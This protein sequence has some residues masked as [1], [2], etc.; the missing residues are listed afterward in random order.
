MYQSASLTTIMF[1]CIIVISFSCLLF[2]A[3]FGYGQA[4]APTTEGCRRVDK[5]KESIYIEFSG[6]EVMTNDSPRIG[7]HIALLR[8]RN[9]LTCPVLLSTVDLITTASPTENTSQGAIRADSRIKVIYQLQD[10]KRKNSPKPAPEFAGV[11]IIHWSILSAGD[12]VLFQV[13][14]EHFKKNLNVV[15]PFMHQWD[16]GISQRA[17][18]NVYFLRDMLSDD[19]ISR[20][21]ERKM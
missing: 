1:R 2:P 18:H 9:N 16:L 8:L 7:Q 4:S 6:T 19:I 3:S 20:A 14:V 11:H 15:V 5:S 10:Y 13:P 17:I 21:S 12:A